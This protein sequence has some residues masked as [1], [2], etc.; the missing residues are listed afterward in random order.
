M[1]PPPIA[2]ASLSIRDFRGVDHLD[3]D[4]RGPDRLPNQLI[5]LAGPNGSGK[6]AVLEAALIATGGKKLVVG[7]TGRRAI[8]TG[9]I[10]F[11]IAASFREG[12][13]EF[14]VEGS[15]Q[16]FPRLPLIRYWYFSSWR[17]PMR[18]GPLNVTAGKSGRRP[19]K[20][21]A[22]R[23]KNVKQILINAA[24]T[25]HFP[26]RQQSLIDQYKDWM[27]SINRSWLEFYPETQSRFSVELAEPNED[28][29]GAFDLFY[30]RPDRERLEVDYLSAG[31]L[32]L[33]LFLAALVLNDDREG[34]VFIDEPELHL[35]PQWHR[36]ILRSLIRLQPKAQFIVA[37]HSPEIYGAARSYERHYLVP[38]DDPR[39]RLWPTVVVE[40]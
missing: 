4:F 28:T 7:P 14:K 39:A 9:A 13:T 3:L 36:P 19:L 27:A 15:S 5:V 20:T 22:N 10:D 24:A 33:F 21:D 32:E 12:E 37:T 11:E 30:S 16:G 25:A 8:R 23:L 26:G 40:A 18:I 34:I 2:L 38:E 1:S 31:Q 29:D 35:D 6:T 17:A